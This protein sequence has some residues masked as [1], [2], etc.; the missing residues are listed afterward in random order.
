MSYERRGLEGAASNAATKESQEIAAIHV[1][2]INAATSPAAFGA[3][4]NAAKIQA[5]ILDACKGAIITA[6]A[7]ATGASGSVVVGAAAGA[8]ITALISEI[9]WAVAAA[10]APVIG[11][12]AA[13][14][15]ASAVSGALTAATGAVVAAWPLA[16]FAVVALLVYTGML[17]AS[18]SRMKD[19]FKQWAESCKSAWSM[20]IGKGK[21]D[22]S[23][24]LHRPTMRP[25][26]VINSDVGRVFVSLE[27][28]T[29]ISLDVQSAIGV[30]NNIPGPVRKVLRKLRLAISA[31]SDHEDGGLV[32]WPLYVDL[33]ASQVMSGNLR[34]SGMAYSWLLFDHAPDGWDPKTHEQVGE[35]VGTRAVVSLRLESLYNAFIVGDKQA[36]EDRV[37]ELIETIGPKTCLNCAGPEILGGDCLSVNPSPVFTAMS[38]LDGWNKA[39][40]SMRI[41]NADVDRARSAAKAALSKLAKVMVLSPSKVVLP[42]SAIRGASSQ[43]R[44]MLPADKPAPIVREVAPAKPTTGG[45]ALAVGLC[46]AAAALGGLLYWRKHPELKAKIRSRLGRSS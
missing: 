2:A 26:D 30:L 39:L 6:V 45:T 28:P 17:M 25:C 36:Q 40:A 46:A 12:A 18:A 24:A 20:P 7:A 29:D 16:A 32:Y 9:V 33:I 37:R 5:T 42:A 19:Q 38:I 13:S 3:Y 34:L 31:S 21:P 27:L 22:P 10:V 14:A 44:P 4:S 35:P 23:D 41:T 11:G 8:S 1:D 15:A 43:M